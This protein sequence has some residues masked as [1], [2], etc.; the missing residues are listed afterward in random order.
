[1]L[2]SM[3]DKND[4]INRIVQGH[5]LLTTKL[6]SKCNF[7]ESL[8]FNIKVLLPTHIQ[9]PTLFVL[10]TKLIEGRLVKKL[11]PLVKK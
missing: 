2:G 1:M 6:P 4:C 5:Q 8:L 9:S 11:S 3:E 10:Y 7:C